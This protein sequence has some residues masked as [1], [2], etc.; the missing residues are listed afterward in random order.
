MATSPAAGVLWYENTVCAQGR[1][2][3][4]GNEPCTACPVGQYGA[5]LGLNSV[6]CSG[7]CPAGRYGNSTGVCA[8]VYLWMCVYAWNGV[9]VCGY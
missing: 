7:P 2:N 9:I 3:S 6:A 1:Y 5:R 4:T 8:F